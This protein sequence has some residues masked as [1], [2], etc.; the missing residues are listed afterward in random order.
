MNPKFR[1][2][3]VRYEGRDGIAWYGVA[4]WH[5]CVYPM[6][7]GNPLEPNGYDDIAAALSACHMKNL[8]ERS[9]EL[10]RV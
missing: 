2:G 1:Y 3:I 9:R 7:F 4:D 8:E 10:R 6:Q 5:I